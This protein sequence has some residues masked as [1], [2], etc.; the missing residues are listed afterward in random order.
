MFASYIRHI[1]KYLTVIYIY[2]YR[3]ST[4]TVELI[5]T[6]EEGRLKEF[7]LP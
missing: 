7:K 5:F 4:E 1:L 6:E 2:K 3:N